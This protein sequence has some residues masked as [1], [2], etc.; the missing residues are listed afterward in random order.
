[1]SM[2]TD[3]DR[4]RASV[5]ICTYN[6]R[7]ALSQTL[8]SLG[9]QSASHDFEVVV[10]V[11]GSTDGTLESLAARPTGFPLRWLWQAN[12]GAAAARNAAA[13]LAVAEVLIFLDD[14]QLADPGL[15]RAHLEA[16]AA[17]PGAL[18]QGAYPLAA[19]ASGHGASLAYEASRMSAMND[20]HAAVQ[21][22]FLW[23]GNFSVNRGVWLAVGGFDERFSHYGG[24][25]TDLGLRVAALGMPL[26]YEPAARSHHLHTVGYR[27]YARNA[28]SEGRATVRL[29]DKH[30]LPLAAL[31]GTAIDGRRDRLMRRLWRSAPKLARAIGAFT[32]A[33]LWL[34]DRSHLKVFQL[35]AARL[36]RRFH[37]IGGIT[38]ALAE[39]NGL[40]GLTF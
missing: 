1:M 34:A 23:G 16:Q 25:D 10:A 29:A 31:P 13:R 40:Q 15:V 24:E 33:G 17:N 4:L 7:G 9:R 39:K 22:R 12:A 18:V 26:V 38:W 28:F 36:V 35:S 6:R 14:D 20:W 37:R 21:P 27:A 3:A 19:G 11:D 32:T 8:D 5:L 2:R 30:G